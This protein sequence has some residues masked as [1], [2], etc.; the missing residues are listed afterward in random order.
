MLERWKPPTVA[1]FLS[2][3]FL[4]RAWK[5]LFAYFD[6]DDL[7][8]LYTAWSM[9]LSDLIIANLTP[10][11]RVYRPLGSA[12]YRTLFFAFGWNP[13]PFRVIAFALLLLNIW[14]LFCLARRLSG[15]LEIA[16]LAA[17]IGAFDYRLVDIYRYGGTIYDILCRTFV[18]LTLLYYIRRR[19]SGLAFNVASTAV[20]CILFTLALNAKE[21]AV[22]LP[23][24]LLAYDWIFDLSGASTGARKR[25][26]HLWPAA[27]TA[28][29]A[30]VALLRKTG[31]G[32]PF[33]GNPA[34]ASHPSLHQ[35]FAT[36]ERLLAEL[37]YLPEGSLN[38]TKVVLLWLLVLGVAFATRRKYLQ[39]CALFILLSPLPVE[40]I[41]Y[42]GFYVMYLPLFGWAIVA[43]GVLVE[44]RNW[45]WRVVWKRPPLPAGTWEPE[46]V[47]LF[48][49]TAAIISLAQPP[50]A[51]ATLAEVDPTSV[52]IQQLKDD[53]SRIH[54]SLPKSARILFLDDQFTTVDWAPLFVLRLLYGDT[55]LV[56]NRVKMMPVQPTR[57]EIATY[58]FVFDYA[59]G[60]LVEIER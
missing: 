40:M 55:S 28:A 56:V 39:F 29:I 52:H 9:P 23:S 15:S 3:W 13:L 16:T 41:P 11:T 6:I 53:M 48:L 59:D 44:G 49:S 57:Q 58:N 35:F 8:N 42:R 22:T 34:Y 10:F 43:A 46:R 33:G 18:L 37:F 38:R 2:A 20:L 30:V 12:F 31:S 32:S 24:L 51:A 50:S 54:P 45:L 36:T 21:M 19:Q 26:L 4:A 17:L 27:A 1:A 7:T 47:F 5:G 25:L 14:L 60:K